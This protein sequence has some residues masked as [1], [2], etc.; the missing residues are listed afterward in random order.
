MTATGTM[1]AIVRHPG[2]VRL[3]RIALPRVRPGWVR[4]RVLLA[5]LCRTDLSCRVLRQARALFALG[6]PCAWD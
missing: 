2:G 4:L 3:E 1:R 6:V 5:G